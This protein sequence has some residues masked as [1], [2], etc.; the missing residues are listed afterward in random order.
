MSIPIIE[1]K[2]YELRAYSKQ[3][4][5]PHRDP[6]AKGPRVFSSVVRIDDM[7]PTETSARRYSTQF[8]AAG[9]TSS[10]DAVDLAMQYGKDIVDGTV[11]AIEL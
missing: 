2:G 5:P 10:N 11:H 6:Y 7:P 1:Y 4:F 8:S 3:V 9:P